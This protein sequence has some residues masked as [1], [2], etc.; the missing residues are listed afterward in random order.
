MIHQLTHAYQL[1]VC[2]CAFLSGHFCVLL[3]TRN[4][5]QPVT[6]DQISTTTT[7]LAWWR[8]S[9]EAQQNKNETC[10]K[11]KNVDEPTKMVNDYLSYNVSAG[12]D[13]EQEHT[14]RPLQKWW[15]SR[16]WQ[17]TLVTCR[18]R[19]AFLHCSDAL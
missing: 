13:N 7:R 11:K 8:G 4:T 15:T 17:V 18:L 5:V 2:V 1:S 3:V 6:W 14:V 19:M 12:R 16:F 9:A 10:Q